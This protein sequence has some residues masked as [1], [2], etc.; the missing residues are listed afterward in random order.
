MA[1]KE[2]RSVSLRSSLLD[3][4]KAFLDENPEFIA[5]NPEYNSIAGFI[6]KAARAHLKAL[7]KRKAAAEEP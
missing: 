5:E 6:D 3:Q 2:F 4:V 1:E 7:E